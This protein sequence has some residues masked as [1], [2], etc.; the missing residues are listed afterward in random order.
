MARALFVGAAAIGVYANSL[1]NGFAL[2]D[3]FIILTNARVHQLADQTAI[4]LTPYWPAFGRELG[5]YR[6]LT[7]FAYALEWAAAGGAAWVFHLCNVALHAT[8]SVLV[9]FLIR[10]LAMGSHGDAFSPCAP[11]APAA[12]GANHHAALLAGL[13]FAVHPVHTEAVANIV[14]Q[15]ELI[16]GVATFGACLIY[17]TRP[18][19]ATRW[20]RRLSIISL[21]VI[22]L[23]AKESAIVLP[24]LLVTLDIAQRRIAWS[25]SGIVGYL[26]NAFMLMFLLSAAAIGYLA[27]RVDVLGSIGGVDAAPSLPFLRE[28]ARLP[29]ALRAW[30]EFVRLL[31]FPADLS[32]DYSP[33]VILPVDA[34][35]P[36]ALLGAAVLA[37]TVL[38]AAL[39]PLSPAAGLPAAWF[40]ITILP[41]SNLLLPIG[42]VVAERL[43]YTPSF[44][45][46]LIAA[47]A[48]RSIDMAA[49]WCPSFH[50]R[51][52]SQS[53]S[54]S[55]T[56]PIPTLRRLALYAAPLLALILMGYRTWTRNPDWK[57]T[58]AV[59]RAL[60]RDH[61]ESYRAQ[62]ST[63]GAAL[64]EGN[65]RLALRYLEL[66]HRMWPHDPQLLDDLASA[67]LSTGDHV[68]AIPLLE[69]SR[70]ELGWVARTHFMLA[71][72]YITAHRF[73]DAL[74]AATRADRLG[75]P[76]DLLYPLLAQAYE[77]LERHGDAIAA[78]RATLRHPASDHW[79]YHAR[80]ARLLARDGA[81]DAAVAHVDSAEAGVN[82]ADTANT[83]LLRRLRDAI[84]RSCYSRWSRPNARQR[85]GC[86]D[87]LTEWRVLVPHR[88]P[89]FAKHS[90]IAMIPSTSIPSPSRPRPTRT[91]L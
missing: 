56:E 43:L 78:W 82:A 55:R 28:S 79:T 45:V 13:I 3:V 58:S 89:H 34:V 88:T 44:A 63:G 24:A 19:A 39:T 31:F 84:T 41:V 21:Y 70:E 9:F 77:G 33:G 7:I 16:A 42:V 57:D 17:A 72:A 47:S 4:W 87:P 75:L 49:C 38:L 36:M 35:T 32:S 10:T 81:I 68:K 76:R 30:P 60:V 15:A 62:W 27:L 23:L 5:A 20:S 50:S 29:T 37:L 66:A 53:R 6:P 69:R 85:S 12:P 52:R 91:S 46:T 8:A 26:R 83:R 11:A 90:Q 48:W 1:A 18:E 80:L 54:R 40:F 74:A 2:D 59:L 61:P 25:G 86:E 73:D 22:G 71:I 67:Y 14:G 51:S 64:A 65:P